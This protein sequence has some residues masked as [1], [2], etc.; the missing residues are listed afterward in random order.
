MNI[1]TVL[2][3]LTLAGSAVAWAQ[4]PAPSSDPLAALKQKSD[5]TDDDRA[6]LREFV[7]QRVADIV[8]SDPAAARQG[9]K[10]LRQAAG[11]GEAYR[12][13]LAAVALPAIGAAVAKSELTP[14]TQLIAIA[15][16]LNVI[17]ARTVFVA[18]LGDERVGVRAAAAVGLRHLRPRLGQ[19]GPDAYQASLTALRDAAIK[20]K[21]RE[22]L[23]AMYQAM[24]YAGVTPAPADARP[25][26]TALVDALEGRAK[27]YKPG[28]EV[29]ALGAEEAAF[30]IIEAASGLTDEDKRRVAAATATVVRFALDM[31]LSAKH[32]LMAVKDS[33]AAERVEL[34][35]NIERL[36]LL[37]ERVLARVVS[38]QKAPTVLESLRKLDRPNT[39]L[40]WK[41]WV[42]LLKPLTNQDFTLAE[43]TDSP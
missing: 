21:S 6:L 9:A 15:D 17:E 4:A 27:L 12:K 2:V 10:A 24:S 39:R 8:G 42:D 43:S 19:G 13:E 30:Q 18:A 14:A 7:A 34:R 31:Y 22:A 16:T 5:F 11:G 33:D 32:D 38:T 35:N 37:G 25:S 29:P 40:Q 26:I 41:A 23:R 20:E 3:I 1:R 28:D 36:V